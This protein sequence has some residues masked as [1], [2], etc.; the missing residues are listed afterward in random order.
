MVT[1]VPTG[2]SGLDVVLNGGL[3]RGSVTVLEGAPG[4][5]KTTL[6]FHFL[7]SGALEHG[8]SGMYITFEELP[9]QLY[10]NM[11]AFGWDLRKLE[12]ENKLRVICM[13]ADA[14]LAQMKR[15]GGL[16]ETIVEE[17]KCKRIVI[18]SISLLNDHAV[19]QAQRRETA[20]M[21]RNILR[22]YGL[23]A[24][25]L[26]ESIVCMNGKDEGHAFEHYLFDGYIE[27]SVKP[28]IEHYRKRVVEIHKLRGRHIIEGEHRYFIT[29]DGIRV[30][31][32]LTMAEDRAI[33]AHAADLSTGIPEFDRVLAGGLRRGSVYM[34]DT[35]SKANY[36]YLL[37]SIICRQIE[38]GGHLLLALSSMNSIIDLQRMC[39]QFGCSLEEAVREQRVW[40]VEHYNRPY[41]ASFRSSI[42][43]MG[44][45][46]EAEYREKL[47]EIAG[48]IE[49]STAKG[50]HWF[51]FSDLN[52]LFVQ[53]G[54][55]FVHRFYAEE[56]SFC[57]TRSVTMLSLCNFAEIHIETASYLE[58][59]SNGVI[60]T[61]VD[62]RYQY[63][64]LT[65]SPTGQMSEPYIIENT[66]QPPFIRL[67]IGR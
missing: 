6:G 46:S 50:N 25:V 61:W 7:V 51:V 49:A 18:D 52:T 65:K 63:I 17:I 2:I 34:L 10:G 20:Y 3:P 47:R 15:P 22:K 8:E 4:T 11:A 41:P 24:F 21:V 40:F 32:A 64:Q 44:D 16:F 53:R 13:T 33:A 19:S 45:I 55:E 62:G 5:G 27:L 48:M 1:N 43:Y 12:R 35:N 30:L 38:S 56:A 23:T 14:L 29:E 37:T 60:R 54:R 28:F 26:R 36:K 57:R 31:P 67:I 9:D 42:T 66:D 58:R 39:A 59:T